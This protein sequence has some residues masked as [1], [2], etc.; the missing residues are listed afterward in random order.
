MSS[1]SKRIQ[2]KDIQRLVEKY[3][4]FAE[5]QRAIP[6]PGISRRLENDAEHSFSLA[7][8]GIA[9]GSKIGLNPEKIAYY[10]TLH[11]LPELYAGDVS[12]WDEKGLKTKSINEDIAVGQ[13]A[14]DLKTTPEIEKG[15]RS[16]R[17]LEDEEARFIFAL[18]KLFVLFMMMA[19]EGKWWRGNNITYE[20]FVKKISQKREQV[21][22][23]LVVLEWYD[24]M[25]KSIALQR[26]RLFVKSQ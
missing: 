10:A 6:W 13:I 16:Y 14:N 12:V 21:K 5:V 23:H 20:M 19:D 8:I 26:D 18:D 7:L 9:L 15:V 11:D 1:K 24:E 4:K 25:L 3:I 2:L 17:K 22:Q